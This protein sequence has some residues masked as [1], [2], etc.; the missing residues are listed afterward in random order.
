M[1]RLDS[2]AALGSDTSSS[3]VAMADEFP[4]IVTPRVT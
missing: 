3:A 1:D 2:A 4:P